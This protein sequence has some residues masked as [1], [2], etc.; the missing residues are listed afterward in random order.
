MVSP[1]GLLSV[2]DRPRQSGGH[3]L[4]SELVFDKIVKII[5]VINRARIFMK[6]SRI[7]DYIKWILTAPCHC[8]RMQ[9]SPSAALAG[10]RSAP[11]SAAP[12]HP[13]PPPLGHCQTTRQK[14]VS[15]DKR[16]GQ[17]IFTTGCTPRR[18]WPIL[19]TAGGARLG[20]QAGTS[21]IVVGTAGR[22]GPRWAVEADMAAPRSRPAGRTCCAPRQIRPE[23]LEF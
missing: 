22:A 14:C 19:P 18:S 21:G 16:P 10:P 3:V 2:D 13:Q 8:L 11:P 23:T 1:V 20:E 4:T 5:V 15:L 6:E 17:M 7:T 12:A 9:F